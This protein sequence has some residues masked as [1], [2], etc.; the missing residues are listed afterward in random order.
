MVI[1]KSKKADRIGIRETLIKSFHDAGSVVPA[2]TPDHCR[3]HERDGMARSSG[4][5]EKVTLEQSEWR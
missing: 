3:R 4:P 1:R 2:L 5:A